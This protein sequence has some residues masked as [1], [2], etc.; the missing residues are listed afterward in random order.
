MALRLRLMRRRD[1]REFSDVERV[2]EALPSRGDGAEKISPEELELLELD[3]LGRESRSPRTDP[4]AVAAVMALLLSAIVI[5]LQFTGPAAAM[6]TAF[7][8][9]CILALIIGALDVLLAGPEPFTDS[10]A[11]EYA[12]R[13]LDRRVVGKETPPSE[14]TMANEAAPPAEAGP[15]KVDRAAVRRRARRGR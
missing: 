7:V 6:T 14:T 4:G 2:V 15:D 5:V 10:T 8:V 12:M 13:V 1:R 3:L 11:A 9:L